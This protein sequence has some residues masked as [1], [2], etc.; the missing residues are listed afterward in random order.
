[1]STTITNGLENIVNT[2]S[3]SSAS[4]TKAIGKDE[5]MKLLLAQLK[6]QNPLNPMDGTDFA[7]QLA[8]FSSLEQLSNLNAEL[9]TQGLNQMTLG[10]A[11]SANMIGKVIEAKNGNTVTANGSAVDINYRLAKDAQKVTINIYDQDGK[12]V[13]TLE[14]TAKKEGMNITTWNCSAI[15]KGNY[16]F[17]IAASDI[18]GGVVTADTMTSGVVT[19]V[20]FKNNTISLTVNGQELALSDVVSVIQP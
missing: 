10:Y 9:K 16:T 11:Q 1:M 8:Q 3:T 17:Q 13:Q 12:L 20:H 18:N 6:N 4:S 15:A 2:S 5:F 19:A 7:A 14:D